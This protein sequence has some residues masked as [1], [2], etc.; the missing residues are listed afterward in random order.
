MMRR[1]L[2][3]LRLERDRVERAIGHALRTRVLPAHV[4]GRVYVD[5]RLRGQDVHD[6]TG[7]RIG[8]ARGEMQ[9]LLER[10][11]PAVVA[12]LLGNLQALAQRLGCSKIKR[13]SRHGKK[14]ARR[15]PGVSGFGVMM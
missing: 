14:A 2:E 10:E 7:A 11:H 8:Y 12:A 5:R 3:M 13:S 6:P 9:F 4:A 1:V 15:N